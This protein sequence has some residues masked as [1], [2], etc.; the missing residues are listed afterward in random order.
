MLDIVFLWQLRE[1]QVLPRPTYIAKQHHPENAQ[2]NWGLDML[3]Q[4]TN[5]TVS[6]LPKHVNFLASQSKRGV[7]Y[8]TAAAAKPDH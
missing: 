3:P 8:E 5:F 1:R 2:S 4:I 7:V 6:F